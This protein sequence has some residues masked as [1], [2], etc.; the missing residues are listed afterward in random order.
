MS[1]LETLLLNEVRKPLE[2]L[3]KS[4]VGFIDEE[5]SSSIYYKIDDRLFAIDIREVKKRNEHGK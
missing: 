5:T 1:H 4:H 3:E 2:D